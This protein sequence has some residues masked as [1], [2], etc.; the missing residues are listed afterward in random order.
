MAKIGLARLIGESE[1]YKLNS[2]FVVA[3]NDENSWS[4][5]FNWFCDNFNWPCHELEC[6]PVMDEILFMLASTKSTS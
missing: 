6:Q 4:L 3:F 2:I 5:K 1:I